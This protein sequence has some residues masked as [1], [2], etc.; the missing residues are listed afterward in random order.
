[1]TFSAMEKTKMYKVLIYQRTF[2]PV[3][4]LWTI[5]NYDTGS[6]C[7]GIVRERE[8]GLRVGWSRKLSCKAAMAHFQTTPS[9]PRSKY[10]VC[11]PASG[12]MYVKCICF[13]FGKFPLR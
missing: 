9:C 4:A 2:N 8:T 10:L 1:M 6:L 5:V 3:K 11:C 13:R 12:T 7:Q